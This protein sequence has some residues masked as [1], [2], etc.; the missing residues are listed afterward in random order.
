PNVHITLDKNLAFY[1]AENVAIDRVV[2]Y[3]AADPDA[4][5][6]RFRAGELDM[7]DELPISQI[8]WLRANMAEAVRIEPFLGLEYIP[9][10]F[11]RPPFDDPRI[12]EALNLGLNRE[13]ITNQ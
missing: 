1:D 7:L 6:R 13:I 2:Y 12:R 8:E 5:L 11:T 3:P 4:A 10:N 9:I